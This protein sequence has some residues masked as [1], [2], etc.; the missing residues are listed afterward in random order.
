MRA[1][2]YVW[3]KKEDENTLQGMVE[4]VSHYCRSHGH[5]LEAKFA[6]LTPDR[7]TDG[8]SQFSEMVQFIG[9]AGKEYLVLVPNAGHLGN[10]LEEVARATLR[11]NDVKAR[12]LC[13]AS[14]S[15]D[16]LENAL[17]VLGIKGVS[18]ERS[19]M[20][21]S[22]MANKAIR[23]RGLGRPPYGYKIG[24]SGTLEVVPE[25]ATIVQLIFNLYTKQ[26]LG[27]RKIVAHLNEKGIANR[28]NSPW[29][30]IT[31]RDLLR[32]SAYVGTY[33]RFGFRL[34]KNHQP[35]VPLN[36]FRL[37]QD[38]MNS[39]TPKREWAALEPFALSGLVFC[40]HCGNK[41]IGM[42]RR[43]SWSRKDGASKQGQYRYY[44]CQSKTNQSMCQ[45]H[46]WRASVLEEQVR[47]QLFSMLEKDPSLKSSS[48]EN[49]Q[50]QE[51]VSAAEKRFTKAFRRVAQGKAPLPVLGQYLAQLDKARKV[52]TLNTS[53]SQSPA[54]NPF[55]KESWEKLEPGDR[56]N[57]LKPLVARIV[58]MDKDVQIEVRLGQTRLRL[59]PS[60]HRMVK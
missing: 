12:V 28:R 11:L 4:A 17:Q 20:I 58:A 7:N 51:E 39:R 21:K 57:L 60:L 40:G 43:Q 46:T 38:M 5:Q 50:L 30:I 2:G 29:N 42:T 26:K 8:K 37:A 36:D 19:D 31:L 35:I 16:P 32:N 27:L 55:E 9:S 23:G 18:R 59:C 3:L 33:T 34:P 10:D 41:M 15:P 14:Q 53:T 24:D 45:Y 54:N 48:L 52:M 1:V 25:E 44:Q 6:D 22:A 47:A 56:R 13:V 49:P